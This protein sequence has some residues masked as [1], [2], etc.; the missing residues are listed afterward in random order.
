MTAFFLFKDQNCHFITIQNTIPKY[1][2]LTKY[3][4]RSD[5][6]QRLV[7]TLNCSAHAQYICVHAHIH[8]IIL[9]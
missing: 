5:N 4:P 9:Q 8:K 3:R 2:V 7:S 6:R 1:E